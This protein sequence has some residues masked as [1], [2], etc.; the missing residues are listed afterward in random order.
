MGKAS[1]Q[2]GQ[3]QKQPKHRCIRC[4][5]IGAWPGPR[6]PALRARHAH[7]TIGPANWCQACVSAAKRKTGTAVYDHNPDFL[8]QTIKD[9]ET[10]NR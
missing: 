10:L 2:K 4:G 9:L 1:R 3:R 7:W 6:N 8:A 5:G